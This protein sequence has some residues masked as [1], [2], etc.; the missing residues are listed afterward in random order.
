[1]ASLAAAHAGCAGEE[2]L[3]CSTGMIGVELPMALIRQNMGNIKL[4]ADGGPEFARAIM[5]TDTRPK[6][7]A[8]A[9]DVD[10]N[11]NHI[12]P[13]EEYSRWCIHLKFDRNRVGCSRVG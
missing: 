2:L 1:M 5:T 8:V 11:P 10:A 3:V 13:I 4:S 9:V 6:E 7:I 12:L